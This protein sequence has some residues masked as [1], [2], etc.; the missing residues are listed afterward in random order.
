VKLEKPPKW[1]HLLFSVIDI[2][3]EE[4]DLLSR[5]KFILQISHLYRK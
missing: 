1:R 2:K 4:V 3:P 5:K